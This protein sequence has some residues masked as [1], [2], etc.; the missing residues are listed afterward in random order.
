MTPLEM[1]RRNE[2]VYKQSQKNHFLDHLPFRS[3]GPIL[4]ILMVYCS[5]PRVVHVRETS[6]VVAGV[7]CAELEQQQ[8]TKKEVVVI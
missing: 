4:I 3:H 2:I 1:K 6:V 5:L 7:G 8:Q